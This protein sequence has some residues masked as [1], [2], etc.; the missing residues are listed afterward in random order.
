MTIE[1]KP[2]LKGSYL[3]T[4]QI[5][6]YK[7]S[8]TTGKEFIKPCMLKAWKKVSKKRLFRN[9]KVISISDLKE[10]IEN[11][12]IKIMKNSSKIQ[13]SSKNSR[14]LALLLCFMRFEYEGDL[15]EKLLCL[16]NYSRTN[17]SDIF[18]ALCSY[19]R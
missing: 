11:R 7:N 12:V 15:Y 9:L 1:Y 17:I 6:K 16:H 13:K 14:A 18:K 3:I 8:Y 5:V 10:D 4:N 19:L 2:L